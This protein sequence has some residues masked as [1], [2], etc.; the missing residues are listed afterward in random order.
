MTLEFVADVVIL[1][2]PDAVVVLETVQ[3]LQSQFNHRRQDF[4]ELSRD[5]GGNVSFC[6]PNWA[7]ARATIAF[8]ST[9]LLMCTRTINN[10]F[11]EFV[12]LLTGEALA[13][14]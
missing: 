7:R 14:D 6:T 1:S 3:F 11:Q 9:R 13:A 8:G 10:G 12:R 5:V 4:G 2:S